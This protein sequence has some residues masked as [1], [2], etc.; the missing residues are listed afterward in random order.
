MDDV[1]RP[2]LARML[3]ISQYRIRDFDNAIQWLTKA[4]AADKEDAEAYLY[5]GYCQIN[6]TKI[7]EAEK[8]F[9]TAFHLDNSET[10]KQEAID[11]L[12]EIGELSLSLGEN[13]IA[14]GAEPRGY[15]FKKLGIRI[16]A[17]A[18]EFSKYDLE[19]AEKIQKYAIAT[20]DQILIDWIANVI[21]AEKEGPQTI[22]IQL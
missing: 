15:E 7:A 22:E 3:G 11:E 14:Q 4:T 1:N 9:K 13:F 20:K 18:L 5:L 12:M 21:L 6:K 2:G 19:L 8:S 17:F 16:M 10:I